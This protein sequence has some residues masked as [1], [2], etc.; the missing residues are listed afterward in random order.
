M[1]TCGGGGKKKRKEKK[2]TSCQSSVDNKCII[3]KAVVVHTIWLVCGR[4][5]ERLGKKEWNKATWTSQQVSTT[6]RASFYRTP[7]FFFSSPSFLFRFER[8]QTQHHIKDATS[9]AT[10]LPF[11]LLS[12]LHFS[13]PSSLWSMSF[14]SFGYHSMLSH[15]RSRQ[16]FRTFSRLLTPTSRQTPPVPINIASTWTYNTDETRILK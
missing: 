11:S 10:G 6:F 16:T 14:G 15:C 1:K 13:S 3:W 12:Y 2:K 5:S 8:D 7:K 4:Q 9:C